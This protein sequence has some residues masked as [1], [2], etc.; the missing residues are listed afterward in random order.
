LI[1]SR[2]LLGVRNSKLAGADSRLVRATS[3][4]AASVTGTAG[5]MESRAALKAAAHG[6]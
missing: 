4:S 6:C 2:V 1:N 3:R 5:I